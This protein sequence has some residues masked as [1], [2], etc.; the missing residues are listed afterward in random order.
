MGFKQSLAWK[1]V[2]N[3]KR[4]REDLFTCSDPATLNTQ[5]SRFVVEIRKANGELYPPKIVRQLLC[6]LMWHLRDMLIPNVPTSLTRRIA[7]L[8]PSKGPWM[9]TF[10]T[11]L[12]PCKLL[13]AQHSCMF[14]EQAQISRQY[15][16]F[17]SVSLKIP[18]N[19][20]VCIQLPK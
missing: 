20:T 13:S 16:F 10:T 19:N 1:K 7:G 4:I 9:L 8:S 18:C 14:N 2:R 17:S 11:K 12:Y 6:G 15:T 3:E 5:L